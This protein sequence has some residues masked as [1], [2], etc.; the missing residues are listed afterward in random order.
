MQVK[1]AVVSRVQL[2]QLSARWRIEGANCLSQKPDECIKS[3][4]L[5][6]IPEGA[7]FGLELYWGGGGDSE[8]RTCNDH[9]GVW[10]IC[11]GHEHIPKLTWRPQFVVVNQVKEQERSLTRLSF[12]EAD[13]IEAKRGGKIGQPTCYL[14]SKLAEE[15]FMVNGVMV[16]ELRVKAWIPE[17]QTH[18]FPAA[19]PF[20]GTASAFT[21]DMAALLQNA[22]G[23]DVS[24]RPGIPNS[25]GSDTEPLHAHR[26]LLAARS[27]VFRQMFFGSA[28]M[29]EAAPC[30]EVCLSDMDFPIANM[31]LDFIYTGKVEPQAW[32]DED[33]V[34]HLLSAGH[35][36]EV[37]SL[38]E[39]CV[40]RLVSSLCEE[41][42]AER[43]MM[44]D[45]LGIQEVKDAALEYICASQA[46]LAVVQSTEA[47]KRLGEQRPQLALEIMAKM[48]APAKRPADSSLPADL[49]SRTV[50]QLKQFCNDRGLPASGN[51]QA[52][53]DRLRTLPRS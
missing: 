33:A 27:P 41:T 50:V 22:D 44:A 4:R 20:S 35:K 52:L 18:R 32:A 12:E 51:K 29:A 40:A 3:G 38:I 15:G 13:G 9:I 23:S 48:V 31:F 11:G 8:P 49:P 26:S 47:F 6:D 53:I 36:Y 16:F 45:L 5:F 37:K 25:D 34:C 46:R 7:W 21:A 2:H 1:E 42:A 10:A 39:A 17:V 43:L 28:G 30:A 14:R 24:L 19:E